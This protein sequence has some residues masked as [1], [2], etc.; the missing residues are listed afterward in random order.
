MR[1]ILATCAAAM[2]LAGCATRD[3]RTPP[4]TRAQAMSR[5]EVMELRI[6]KVWDSVND[7]L[8]HDREQGISHF[9]EVDVKSGSQAGKPLTLPYDDWNVGK[10]PPGEGITVFVAPADWVRRGK[11]SKGRPFGGW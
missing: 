1:L 11:D 4:L 7:A 6:V 5:T 9:I 10:A 2:L 3:F 8:D